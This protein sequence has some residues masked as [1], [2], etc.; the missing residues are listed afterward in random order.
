MF[1]KAPFIY[2]IAAE[3]VEYMMNVLYLVEQGELECNYTK[4]FHIFLMILTCKIS[5]F[6]SSLLN[7]CSN[8]EYY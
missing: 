1:F 6:F 2:N 5:Y 3:L 4:Q 8:S 7:F